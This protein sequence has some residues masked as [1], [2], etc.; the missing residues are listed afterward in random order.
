[1]EQLITIELFGQPYTFKADT[2]VGKARWVADALVREVEK[3]E[4]Q[5]TDRPSNATK[6]TIMILAAL[7]LASDNH[8]MKTKY[9]DLLENISERSSRLLQLLDSGLTEMPALRR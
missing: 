7:N 4:A 5:Q 9:S 8:E 3:V 2:E 1:L 6:L